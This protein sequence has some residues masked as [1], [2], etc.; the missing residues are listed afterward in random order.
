MVDLPLPARPLIK[1][2]K[3]ILLN[4]SSSSPERAQLASGSCSTLYHVSASA[5]K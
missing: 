5:T 2:G 4:S 1:V 3:L